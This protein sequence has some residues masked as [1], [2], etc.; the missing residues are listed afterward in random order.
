MNCSDVNHHKQVS[1][2]RVVYEV[3]GGKEERKRM[4]YGMLW[5][6]RCWNEMVWPTAW[7]QRLQVYWRMILDSPEKKWDNI[8][9]DPLPVH[10]VVVHYNWVI[11][12]EVSMAVVFVYIHVCTYPHTCMCFPWCFRMVN[13][14]GS[15]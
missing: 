7:G 15:H 14:V 1:C 2:R 9:S 5:L 3:F 8:P 13:S 11:I 4:M 6:N 12:M 10:I